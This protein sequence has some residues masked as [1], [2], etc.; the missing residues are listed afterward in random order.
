MY[1]NGHG[2]SVGQPEPRFTAGDVLFNCSEGIIHHWELPQHKLDEISVLSVVFTS[3]QN[4]SISLFSVAI[5][6]LLARAKSAVIYSN[7]KV[8]NS[9]K[10]SN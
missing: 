2:E 7:T 8:S 5:Q 6:L 4:R 3:L 1:N 10:H 9:L